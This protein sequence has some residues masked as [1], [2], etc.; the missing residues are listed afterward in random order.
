MEEAVGESVVIGAEDIG[1]V[2]HSEEVE[3]STSTT[4]D[5]S[6]P[7]ITAPAAPPA[8]VAV[9][10]LG[11]VYSIPTLVPTTGPVMQVVTLQNAL[12]SQPAG[13]TNALRNV[14]LITIQPKTM[15]GFNGRPQPISLSPRPEIRQ[16][17]PQNSKNMQVLNFYGRTNNSPSTVRV[18]L[19]K[20]PPNPS[21]KV[22]NK[23]A[24]QPVKAS[25]SYYKELQRE[26]EMR[27]F[28][29]LNEELRR[30]LRIL[31]DLTTSLQHNTTFPFM[32]RVD[33]V[34]DGAPDYDRV[35][36]Q[37]MWLSR[38]KEKFRNNDYT[39]LTQFVADMRLIL[40][41]CYRYNGPNHPITKK[42]LRLEQ[43]FEQKITLLPVDLRAQCA[44]A[45]DDSERKAR[46]GS[47]SESYFSP[48]L[49]RVRHERQE[50]ERLAKERKAEEQRKR[51][52]ERERQRCIWAEKMMNPEV[53]AQM[54]TMWEIPQIGH[55]LHLARTALNVG[56]IAQYE[57]EH[58]FLMPEASL[59]LA[60][61]VTSLLSSPNQRI[62]LAESP[63]TPYA[64]WSA[65]I[66]S[67]VVEWYRTYNRE[68]RNVIKGKYKVHLILKS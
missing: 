3:T 40:E 35:I 62:K 2:V 61:L 34:K 9:P 26:K 12:P 18:M 19:P 59:L 49:H 46:I 27:E 43:C 51:R 30:G 50:R 10:A 58:M 65:R 14:R 7:V 57:L 48:L 11:P 21:P 47:S 5:P 53:K 16:P 1:N 67:R 68:G 54:R 25:P 36:T 55:F 37:P 45:E 44:L 29:H 23:P 22:L 56:E 4:I 20:A 63:P 39:V 15:N 32:E 6:P 13:L 66:G 24:P 60:T 17:Q 28:S 31:L 64:I 52:E 38:I 41:N 33:P 8:S 42:A